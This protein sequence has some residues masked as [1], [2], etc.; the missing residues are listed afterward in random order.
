[1]PI[2]SNNKSLD[3]LIV[4][5]EN[6]VHRAFY[7][8]KDLNTTTGKSSGIFYGVI[9][10]IHTQLIRMNPKVV[11]LV[12]GYKNS[13][14]KRLEIYSKY[15]SNRKR[16]NYIDTSQV[17]DLKSFFSYIGWSQ[18]YND[19]GW[20]ADDVIAS[21]VNFYK[22]LDYSICILSNDHDF[23]QLITDKVFCTKYDYKNKSYIN[24]K[25]DYIIKKYGVTPI[26]LVDVY[27]LIGENSDNIEGV[28]RIG[29]KTAL[30]LIKEF[31]SVEELLN[32]V[33]N[34][35]KF[36]KIIDKYKDRILLNKSLIDLSNKDVELCYI[37]NNINHKAAQNLLDYYQI[38]KFKVSDFI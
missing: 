1:M 38:K 7:V 2:I 21:L 12:W 31:N 26:Q 15:K 36:G 6:L 25:Y 8:Y 9:S 34:I 29:L 16:I 19:T 11:I 20:E 30:K 10:I 4:D 23:Y 33:D 13:R 17:N 3:L 28:P 35:N 18:Y 32:N 37:K 24:C 27:S 5:C 22:N 14:K